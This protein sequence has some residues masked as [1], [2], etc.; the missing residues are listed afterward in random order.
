MF[1]HKRW[2]MIAVIVMLAAVALAA[3]QP[4][5]VE[6]IV[7]VTRVTTETV[8]VEGQPVEVTRI[9]TETVEI[10]ATPE[11]SGE[12]ARTDLVVC[13]AQEPETLYTYGG[14]MLVQAAVTH[15]FY[16]DLITTLSY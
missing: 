1:N 3:C 16:E 2:A 15:A 7:E 8:E 5:T 12:E 14:S 9:V 4:Q 10:V 6:K 11:T 13:M